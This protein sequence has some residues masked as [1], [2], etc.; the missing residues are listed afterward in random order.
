[1][2]SI[3]TLTIYD[4]N[5]Q[6]S[7]PARKSLCLRYRPIEQTSLAALPT[8]FQV[9]RDIATKLLHD[10]I[11]DAHSRNWKTTRRRQSQNCKN[12]RQQ[13]GQWCRDYFPSTY[14]TSTPVE[15][16]TIYDTPLSAR[17]KTF[18]STV[19][20]E[21]TSL[22]PCTHRIYFHRFKYSRGNARR[23]P[24]HG[25]SCCSSSFSARREAER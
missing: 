11:Q 8:S 20:N 9:V 15:A 5:R 13:V 14:P 17:I 4:D 25:T 6:V 16:W 2:F 24:R 22:T 21:T 1:M 7:L 10:C 3:E 23:S 12:M 19:Q 18:L